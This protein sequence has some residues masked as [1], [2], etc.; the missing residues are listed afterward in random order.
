MEYV[1]NWKAVVGKVMRVVT[2]EARV[3]EG[4]VQEPLYCDCGFTRPLFEFEDFFVQLFMCHTETVMRVRVKDDVAAWQFRSTKSVCKDLR[5]SNT[6]RNA[7]RL[8]NEDTYHWPAPVEVTID[9]VPLADCRR[10]VFGS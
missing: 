2:K 8:C 9:G 5:E 4:I 1:R 7:I 6:P 10:A 3:C